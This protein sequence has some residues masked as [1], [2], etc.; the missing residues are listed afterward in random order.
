MK[1]VMAETAYILSTTTNKYGE[2]E[3]ESFTT[4]LGRFRKITEI[5]KGANTEGIDTADAIMWFNESE[6]IAEG[7]L[8]Y[9]RGENWR[10]DRLII[11]T[12]MDSTD[13]VFI[14]VLVNK[15]EINFTPEQAS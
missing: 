4:T 12:R 3:V 10:V 14:K 13:I 11:A 8:I 2:Q 6:P 15:H 9:M 5:D 7:T 1:P